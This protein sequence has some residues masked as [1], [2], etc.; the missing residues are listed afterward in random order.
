MMVNQRGN[1]PHCHQAMVMAYPAQLRLWSP[2]VKIKY[3]VQ[4]GMEQMINKK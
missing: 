4:K 3:K 1:L 2:P